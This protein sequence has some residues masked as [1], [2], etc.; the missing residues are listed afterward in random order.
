MP[1]KS[2]NYEKRGL[3]RESPLFKDFWCNYTMDQVIAMTPEELDQA[4]DVSL[5]KYIARRI[6]QEKNWNFPDLTDFR[7]VR[8]SRTGVD[9]TPRVIL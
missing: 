9:K 4:I 5:D 8:N 2:D 6:K 1:R 3:T 7:K